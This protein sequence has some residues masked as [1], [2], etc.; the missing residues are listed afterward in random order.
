MEKKL[1]NPYYKKIVT[2][3]QNPV[4]HT[5]QGDKL[6]DQVNSISGMQWEMNTNFIAVFTLLLNTAVMYKVPQEN[7]VETL[8]VFTDMQFDQAC[9]DHTPFEQVEIMYEKAGYKMPK[10]VFWNLRSSSGGFPI[11]SKQ[12]GVALVS[13]FSAELMRL[14]T[15]G[16][17]FDPM[18]ILEIALEKYKDV[19]IHKT[20]EKKID[21]M[22]L[23]I[24]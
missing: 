15:E 18:T 4:L 14:F 23:I 6:T 8:F 12:K 21:E 20:D 17:D 7:M 16:K 3:S 24:E 10:I 5:V 1:K 13:G 9:S 19:V 2:F 11:T 22:E